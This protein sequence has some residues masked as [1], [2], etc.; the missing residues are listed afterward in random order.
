M[1]QTKTTAR[2]GVRLAL[3]RDLTVEEGARRFQYGWAFEMMINRQ[4]TAEELEIR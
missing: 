4:A 3:R 1:N 2:T